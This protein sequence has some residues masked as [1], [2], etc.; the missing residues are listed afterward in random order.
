MRYNTRIMKYELLPDFAK[1]YKTKGFDV[2]LVKNSY[3]LFKV[4]SKRVEGKA[5]PVLIQEYIGTIDPEKGLLPK[6]V[7]VM[8]AS[9][10]LSLLEFGL[11]DFVL[12]NFRERLASTIFN[13][14]DKSVYIY[15]A[16]VLFMYGHANE[17]FLNLSFLSTYITL[18]DSIQSK[19][20][21]KMIVKLADKIKEYFVELIPD[22][23]DRDYL[24]I[25]LRELKVSKSPSP[26]IIYPADIT[27]IFDKYGIK[28]E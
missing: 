6:K 26:K 27:D 20:S 13:I 19:S 5:Y 3:Q 4:S 11:S 2:R 9:S 25:R 7:D 18:T 12:K 21:Q 14:D 15:M 17:R 1:P 10:S 16:V 23:G 22:E 24:I 28:Y 8:V